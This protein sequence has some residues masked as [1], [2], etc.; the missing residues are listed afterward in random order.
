M[1]IKKFA[2]LAEANKTNKDNKTQTKT[3]TN[4]DWNADIDLDPKQ[5]KISKPDQPKSTDKVTPKGA[6][7]DTTNASLKN[8]LSI[9]QISQ[10]GD[11]FGSLDQAMQHIDSDEMSDED[12]YNSLNVPNTTGGRPKPAEPGKDIGPLQRGM[13][14]IPAELKDVPALLGQKYNVTFHEVR[15]LPGMIQRSIRMLGRSLFGT[16]TSQNLEDVLCVST[17]TNSERE[18]NNV[19]G[20]AKQNAQQ[21][22]DL[23]FD[24]AKV[25]PGYTAKGYLSK[26]GDTTFLVISD[27][28]GKYIYSWPSEYDKKIQWKDVAEGL[29]NQQARLPKFESIELPFLRMILRS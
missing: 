16:L 8:N 26:V 2:L 24:F 20:Y 12:F 7:R 23:H 18:V 9:D 19:A 10:M 13:T 11:H 1:D 14:E 25:M 5:H 3:D 4:V 21:E 17:F 6:S 29:P 27:F 22:S 28:A 15:N